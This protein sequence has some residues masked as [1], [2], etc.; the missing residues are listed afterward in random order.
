MYKN[1]T[2][3]HSYPVGR[4]FVVPVAERRNVGLIEN[5]VYENV[6]EKRRRNQLTDLVSSFNRVRPNTIVLYKYVYY[7]FFMSV[8]CECL[9]R[10]VTKEVRYVPRVRLLYDTLPFDSAVW[11]IIHK[12]PSNIVARYRIIRKFN[13]VYGFS[14][15][16]A[17]KAPKRVLNV[18]KKKKKTFQINYIPSGSCDIP[19]ETWC[20]CV[21]IGVCVYRPPCQPKSW[22]HKN[23]PVSVKSIPRSLCSIQNQKKIV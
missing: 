16:F 23:K 19:P 18:Y 2:K 13:W 3:I 14:L 10:K 6:F 20:A 11:I 9:Y 1:R 21:K 17:Q 22:S 15:L 12:R 8:D 5:E 7:Y 4:A